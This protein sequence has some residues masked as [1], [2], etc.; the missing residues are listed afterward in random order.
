MNILLIGLDNSSETIASKHFRAGQHTVDTSPDLATAGRKTELAAEIIFLQPESDNRAIEDLEQASAL[1]PT[2]PV[3][4]ICPR[5]D[6]D[7]TLDAWR[8]GAADIAFLPLKEDALDGIIERAKQRTRSLAAGSEPQARLHYLDETG[9]ER[10]IPVTA[11]KFTV[12]RSSTNDLVLPQVNISRSQ[13]EIS[14]IE[15]EYTLRDLKSKHGT[16]LNGARIEEANL[17]HGDRLQLGGLR[18]QTLTFHQGDLLQSLLGAESM[19]DANLA[20]RGFK[21]MGMLLSTLRALSSI[22]LLDDLL[23]LVVDAAIEL[24]GAERGFI[25]LQ[26]DN[27]GLSFRCARNAFKSPL[28]GSSFKTSR[29]VPEEVY[30]TGKRKVINDLDIDTHAADHSSTRRLGVRS[31]SCVPL[32]Y[33]TFHDSG[34]L[35]S[36]GRM[37]TIGVLYVDSQNIGTGLSNTQIDALD[38]LASEAAMAI[39][40][41]RLYKESQEKR[42]LDEQLAIAQEIQQALLPSP[43]RDLPFVCARSQNFP[44]H[45]VGGDYFDYFDLEGDRFGFALG[46]VAGKGMPA[47]LL[48]SVLQGI[49]SA[50][51]L[52]NLPLPVMISNVNRNLASRGTGNRFVTFFFGIL[53]AEGNCTYTNA[54]HNPPLLVSPDGSLKEL[55][56]GGLVL[57]LFPTATYESG[58]VRFQPGDHLVLFTDG[59]LE[60][61]DASGEEFG[62]DRLQQLLK[63]NAKASAADILQR[64]NEAINEFSADTPQ[65]DDITMMILGYQEC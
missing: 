35:S 58:T 47:A 25:M 4:L 18:G 3:V 62:D 59:V 65:H 8:A 5:S 64:L 7:I 13:A 42:K 9:K 51:T 46:D 49:F 2:L 15:G 12:G 61:R 28:D 30:E 22:P 24:T 10:W 19:P 26:D 41:A 27:G 40:N 11:P 45:E 37:E 52:L 54:G 56:D 21:E 38:T 34:S 14:M 29:R 53:D 31:I 20:V 55:T 44:C 50:Q 36:I 43:N 39:Y 57:G 48:T 16:F 1:F 32:R 6:L 17:A 60:A 33:L 63:E 23:S